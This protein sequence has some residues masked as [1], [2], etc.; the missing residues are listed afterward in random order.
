MVS[1]SVSSTALAR[2]GRALAR[3]GNDGQWQDVVSCSSDTHR[4][5]RLRLP[6]ASWEPRQFDR[7][8]LETESGVEDNP[9]VGREFG[10]EAA[11]KTSPHA[12]QTAMVAEQVREIDHL[13]EKSAAAQA[14]H[15]SLFDLKRDSV[16]ATA[17]A[18]VANAGFSLI[19]EALH[20]GKPYL[21]VP[22]KSQFEQIFNAYY[23]NQMGYGAYWEELE[24]EKVES[25]LFNLDVYRSNLQQY[26]R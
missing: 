21:A 18:I 1:P 3:R 15:G 26:L 24:K 17:N 14:K 6:G 2:R 13:K 11:V 25:F 8:W 5:C 12:R 22:V 7:R 9:C 19:S 10:Q 20:L 23:I 16:E 4:P